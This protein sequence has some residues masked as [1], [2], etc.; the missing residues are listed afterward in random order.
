MDETQIAYQRLTIIKDCS[1]L[2]AK[3]PNRIF[4][5]GRFVGIM[6]QKKVNIMIP[7]GTYNIMIQ[8]PIPFLY[9]TDQVEIQHDVE[10]IVAFKNRERIWDILFT[11]DLALW[12]AGFF[13]SLPSPW[14]L[15]YEIST[16]TFL[17]LWLIYEFCIR[18]KYYRIIQRKVVI[19][20]DQ[21]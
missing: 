18:K 8:S 21:T 9:A 5:N 12:I 16:N 7:K 15:I 17:A 11:I 2:M 6:Q 19:H 20:R 4:I 13:V 3:L 10:N 1:E 14:D